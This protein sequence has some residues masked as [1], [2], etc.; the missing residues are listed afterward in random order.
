MTLDEYIETEIQEANELAGQT[1]CRD[2]VVLL[3]SSF[4]EHTEPAKKESRFLLYEDDPAEALNRF[5]Q[6]S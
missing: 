4:V 5:C 3:D 6:G 2:A 1:I